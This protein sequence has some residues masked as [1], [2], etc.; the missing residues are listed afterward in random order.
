MQVYLILVL[1]IAVL[2]SVFAV[3]NTSLVDLKFLGWTFPQISLVM[4]I[5]SSFTVGALAAFFLS[6]AKLIRSAIK[7]RELANTNRKLT[8]EIDRLQ[9][10][11]NKKSACADAEQVEELN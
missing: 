8:E 4:V 1:I 10:E 2:V 3:E 6:V 7:M 5:V 11:I 9:S